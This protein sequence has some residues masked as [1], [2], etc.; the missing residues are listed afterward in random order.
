MQELK[1]AI[2]IQKE[3]L[4]ELSENND[5]YK[6]TNPIY[7]YD[8]I[9]VI[10]KTKEQA[11]TKTVIDHFNHINYLKELNNQEFDAIRR[12]VLNWIIGLIIT[13]CFFFIILMV[14][15]RY[16]EVKSLSII[17]L[18]SLIIITCSILVVVINFSRLHIINK[19]ISG[20]FKLD[21]RFIKLCIIKTKKTLENEEKIDTS[22]LF[23]ECGQ[24]A[25][26][27]G[28]KKTE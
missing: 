27:C 14:T 10:V 6:I 18:F 7:G 19:V 23:F 15:F 8:H 9:Q 21:F 5:Y 24:L 1:D 28:N 2:N 16:L 13:I 4:P 25:Q 17:P 3:K 20:E 12:T 11:D 26:E 22:G